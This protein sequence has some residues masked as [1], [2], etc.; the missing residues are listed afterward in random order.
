MKRRVNFTPQ[1]YPVDS[2]DR[3]ASAQ[4]GGAIVY[5]ARDCGAYELQLEGD[6]LDERHLPRLRLVGGRPFLCA[7][8]SN[9]RPGRWVA[10]CPWPKRAQ[11]LDVRAGVLYQVDLRNTERPMV[12]ETAIRA[13][14]AE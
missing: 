14:E 3:M 12:R 1:P 2:P 5:L 7:V 10:R 4:F 8:F 11:E 6:E 9:V 13:A